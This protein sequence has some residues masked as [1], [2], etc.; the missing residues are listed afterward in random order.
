MKTLKRLKLNHLG[1]AELAEREMKMVFGGSCGC[2]CC[3]EGGSGLQ[4]N[5]TANVTSGKYS[6]DCHNVT[7]ADYDPK[8][9]GYKSITSVH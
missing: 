2:G 9:G 8:T 6:P 4:D 3:S 7:C 5:S 1:K